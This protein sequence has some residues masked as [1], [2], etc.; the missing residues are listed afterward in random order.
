MKTVNFIFTS[1]TLLLVTGSVYADNCDQAA[2]FYNKGQYSSART[3][4]S[5]LLQKGEACAEY[6]MGLMYESG[7]GFKKSEENRKKGV[8][9]IESAKEKG[10]ADAIKFMNSY[11]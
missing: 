10:Y 2:Y 1:L 5:P 6:Y 4:L 8:R 7:S 9:L 11:H 3:V